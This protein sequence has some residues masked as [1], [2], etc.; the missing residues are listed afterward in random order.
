MQGSL[1]T[2]RQPQLTKQPPR[3]LQHMRPQVKIKCTYIFLS[4]PSHDISG[5]A[6]YA[7]SIQP[8][9]SDYDYDSGNSYT[10]GNDQDYY[11]DT[12]DKYGKNCSLFSF[13]MIC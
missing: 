11:D 5:G 10:G 8:T 7:D 2:I 13:A 9:F 1:E 6:T 12:P 4:T 3:Q